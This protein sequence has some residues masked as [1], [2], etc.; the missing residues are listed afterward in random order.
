MTVRKKILDPKREGDKIALSSH[1]QQVREA[2]KHLPKGEATMMNESAATTT[3]ET[4]AAPRKKT[5]A[6]KKPAKKV[7]A[8]KAAANGADAGTT[9]ATIAKS[10]KME[11][12]KARRILRTADGVPEAGSRWT[13]TRAA[14]VAKVKSILTK[15]TKDE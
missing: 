9:L 6:K 10:M 15:A 5:I 2:I 1:L 4:K 13:W 8:K 14:D 12:R 11:P 3:E 7:V